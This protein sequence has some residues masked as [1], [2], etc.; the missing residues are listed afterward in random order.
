MV[1]ANYAKARSE[2]AKSIGLGQKRGKSAQAK[3]AASA[4]KVTAD[5]P[6][7]RGRKKVA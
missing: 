5:A 2:L 6:K 7:K 1:A 4:E 3:A